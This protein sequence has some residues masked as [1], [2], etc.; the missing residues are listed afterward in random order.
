[1]KALE[2]KPFWLKWRLYLFYTLL[3]FTT[4]CLSVLLLFIFLFVL[5]TSLSYLNIPISKDGL[6]F[7]SLNSFL[8]NWAGFGSPDFQSQHQSSFKR[9]QK[10]DFEGKI[11][12]ILRWLLNQPRSLS[13]VSPKHNNWIWGELNHESLTTSAADPHLADISRGGR[14]PTPCPIYGNLLLMW[15]YSF[16]LPQICLL[17]KVWDSNLFGKHLCRWSGTL[18]TFLL[19]AGS[20]SSIIWW[21]S[22][23]MYRV[24]NPGILRLYSLTAPCVP[25]KGW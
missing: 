14:C 8:E 16:L 12:F 19:M 4:S 9:A 20:W 21:G 7:L 1:M 10:R 5:C 2:F 15:E 6:W 23:L 25:E 18:W 3:C 22:S 11:D 24:K 17:Q 13:K